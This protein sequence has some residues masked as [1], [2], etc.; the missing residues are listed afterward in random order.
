MKRSLLAI[1]VL[2]ILSVGAFAVPNQLTYSGRLLQNGA[3]VNSDLQMTF[4]IWTDP[5][6][7]A[8]LWST[9]N[10]TVPVNQG[11]YSV[12][13]DQV[14]PNVFNG[15]NAYLE[16]IIDPAGSPETLA[17][18]TKINSVGY[19][20]Q[21]GGL[22]M[23]GVQSVVVSTN[24]FVGIG[25]TAPGGQLHIAG[26]DYHGLNIQRSVENTGGPGIV[27]IKT[28]GTVNNPSVV[29]AN[30]TLFQ[31]RLQPY[32]NN[33]LPDIGPHFY[34]N[35][36]GSAVGDFL[37]TRLV[38]CTATNTQVAQTRMTINSSGN[39]GI[40]VAAPQAL[41]SVGNVGLAGRKAIFGD[42]VDIGSTG[43]NRDAGYLAVGSYYN[44][45]NW[46]ATDDDES[47]IQ[48]GS[49]GFHFSYNV[50]AP[51]SSFTP[52]VKMTIT[53]G[54]NVGIGT[55][56]PGAKL[57]IAG[58][59]DNA[60]ALIMS[61][62]GLNWQNSIRNYMSSGTSR[63]DFHVA[64]TIG[65]SLNVLSLKGNGNVG[66]GTTNPQKQ[67]H[68][69]GQQVFSATTDTP[70]EGR[71]GINISPA[72]T[73]G[74]ETIEFYGKTNKS[75]AVIRGRTAGG[76][77]G[78]LELYSRTGSLILTD[79]GNVGIGTSTPLANLQ[80][81][82][83]FG[84]IDVGGTNVLA[85]NAYYSSGWKYNTTAAS[86]GIILN[87][88]GELSF[89]VSPSGTAGTLNPMSERAR[90]DTNGNFGINSTSPTAKL[91]VVGLAE[92]ANNAA[93]IA[94]GLTAGAVY[95]TGEYVKVVY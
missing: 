94:A 15:D 59:P 30:D 37:P 32:I 82:T 12:A 43:P 27:A 70:Y 6:A 67:L 34:I 14:N 79:G 57:E 31:V 56:A 3:L 45:S 4:K 2:A 28:R 89:Y 55:T 71:I 25:M 91:Q 7:G 62:S 84:L 19:A 1:L 22:S 44:G 39:V 66:I 76:N 77:N 86:N 24:G 83:R 11:I 35:A 38:F 9:N 49:G 41:L 87:A 23:G 8:L 80:I 42:T 51:G 75:L 20:L 93:A 78:Q 18:R 17:P 16:V 52:S 33:N 50:T 72:D 54:G 48:A 90:F 60:P 29:Q 85:N 92:Y 65:A 74:Y 58:V 47:I 46:I 95:R 61:Q 53:N 5:T 64:S 81:N 68:L 88:T 26:S 40:G 63:M 21:A 69:T 36:D 13:L 10:I 73:A